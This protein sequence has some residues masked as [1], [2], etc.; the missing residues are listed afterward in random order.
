MH[1]VVPEYVWTPDSFSSETG[2]WEWESCTSKP[3]T[4]RSLSYQRNCL[5]SLYALLLLEVVPTPG[6]L[7]YGTNCLES[8]HT[9]LLFDAVRN[10][11]RLPDIYG[12]EAVAPVK[13]GPVLYNCLAPHCIPLPDPCLTRETVLSPSMLSYY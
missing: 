5:E 11:G 3:P 9:F 2:I 1:L 7:T 12:H 8:I 4:P 6:S 10:I 13:L